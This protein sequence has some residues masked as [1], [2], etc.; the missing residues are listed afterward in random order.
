MPTDKHTHVHLYLSPGISMTTSTWK[1][2][3]LSWF[4]SFAFHLHVSWATGNIWLWQWRGNW[5]DP[6]N[7]SLSVSQCVWVFSFSFSQHVCLLTSR[8]NLLSSL[9]CLFFPSLS[10]HF[11]NSASQYVFPF[12][13]ALVLVQ[14]L[15]WKQIAITLWNCT[16]TSFFSI[17]LICKHFLHCFPSLSFPYTPLKEAATVSLSFLLWIRVTLAAFS[18]LD[19]ELSIHFLCWQT[20]LLLNTRAHTTL[21]TLHRIKQYSYAHL[22]SMKK[23]IQDKHR[24]AHITELAEATRETCAY[25][26]TNHSYLH[27]CTHHSE[28]CPQV[29]VK[30]NFFFRS[31]MLKRLLI[32]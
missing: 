12:S 22:L 30:L 16:F 29:A 4:C 1:P 6:V 15:F 13:S 26:Q 31:N 25:V 9:F 18:Q 2:P 21:L 19:K 3:L 8:L 14:L 10:V 28:K 20:Q 32:G 7:F 27:S 17:S 11:H 5:H 23:D 24:Y